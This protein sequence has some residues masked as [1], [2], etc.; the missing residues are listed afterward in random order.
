MRPNLNYP[1]LGRAAVASLLNAYASAPDYPLTP[2]EVVA[3]FNAVY[4]G[5]TYPI[6]PTSSWT[7]AQVMTYF[8]SL[9]TIV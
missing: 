6:N 9:Y 3:M 4:A 2:A 8:Q 5:G 7:T 1:A